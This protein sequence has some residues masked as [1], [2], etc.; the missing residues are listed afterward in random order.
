MKAISD[1]CDVGDT[2]CLDELG[3]GFI[4]LRPRGIGGVAVVVDEAL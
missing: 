4:L 1:V 2:E 3:W